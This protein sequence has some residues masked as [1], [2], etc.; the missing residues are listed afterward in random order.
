[1]AQI[2]NRKLYEKSIIENG[3]SIVLSKNIQIY[4]YSRVNGRG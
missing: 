4:Q 2:R 1:M 3:F